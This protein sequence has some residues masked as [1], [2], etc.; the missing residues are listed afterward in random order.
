VWWAWPLCGR[1]TRGT[2]QA[3][4]VLWPFL[5]YSNDSRNGYWALDAPWPLI[6]FSRGPGEARHTRFWPLYSFTRGDGLE[7]TSYLW[8]IIRLRRERTTFA[9]RDSVWVVPLYQQLHRTD[10][11]TGVKSSW[12]KAFPLFQHERNGDWSRGSFP[13]LDPFWRNELIDR[14]FS[15]MWKLYEW[16]EQGEMRRERSLLGLW[17]RERDAGE[18]RSSFSVLWSRRRYFDAGVRVKETSL[19]FGLLRWRV[20]EGE[21][22]DMLRPAFPGPGWPAERRRAEVEE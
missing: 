20:T 1:K 4:T 13:T 7:S 16:E 3:T 8:P 18:D 19:L 14:H 11:E 9:E 15:W 5:G 21:G 10:L 12:H 6:R 17:M 22:F 2:Y